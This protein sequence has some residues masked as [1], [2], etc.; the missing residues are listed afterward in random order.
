MAIHHISLFKRSDGHRGGVEKFAAH[1]KLAFPDLNIW[2]LSDFPQ[3]SGGDDWIKAKAL[4]SWLWQTGKI[5]SGD[6]V[7]ADG[8]WGAGL[9]GKDVKLVSVCH[10]S[11]VGT[12]AQNEIYPWFDTGLL[13]RW[14]AAQKGI[15]D[16]A[17]LVVSVSKQAA[18]ELSVLYGLE[19]K[20]ILNGV[21]GS[22]YGPLKGQEVSDLVLHV[23]SPGRKQEEMVSRVAQTLPKGVSVQYLNVS[24]TQEQE[25][26]RWR[27]GS[28]FFQPSLYEGL[29]YASLEAAACGL[30]V[31]AYRTG[32]W[33]DTPSGFGGVGEI[34]DDHDPLVYRR[35]IM[36]VLR[37]RD[38]YK[39]RQWVM[40]HAP[41]SRFISQWQKLAQ[42]L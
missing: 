14:A 41:I 23:A 10:G 12:A 34:V 9:V 30:P 32:L 18:R 2:A 17:A 22:I 8:F 19:S 15:Y 6:I 35:A 37:N 25:A 40:K 1:L 20:V 4:N 13:L 3:S 38:E 16:Q 11:Y 39:P 31:V 21:D 5:Q 24:G 26:A 29:S 27:Q 36:R 42:G 28:V 7:I 33:A